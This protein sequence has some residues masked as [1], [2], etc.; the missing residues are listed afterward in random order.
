MQTGSDER[1][2][3]NVL[4][5]ISYLVGN[6]ETLLQMK[7]LSPRRPF[8]KYTCEFLSTLSKR[9]MTY[10]NIRKYPDLMTF[11]FWI[12][13]ASLNQMKSEHGQ[14]EGIYRIGRGVSF[15]IAPSNVPINFAY[16]MVAA[17]LTGNAAIVRVPSKNHEQIMV[18]VD[19]LTR[20]LECYQEL[21]P[22]VCLIR[23]ERNKEINDLLSS[24]SDV[25]II[26]GGDETIHEIR[27]SPL[28]PRATEI[29]FADRYSLAVIDADY[30]L[31]YN[32]AKK[33]AI[34]FYNDTYLN[35]QNACTSPILVAWT[36]RDREQAKEIFWGELHELV[37]EKY[38]FQ[39]IQGVNKLTSS[40]LAAA[41]LSENNRI[42]V[43]RKKDN[44]LVRVILSE[45]DENLVKYK[46]NSGYFYEYDFDDILELRDL[47]NNQ[48]CQTIGYIGNES[49]LL[50]LIMSG[51]KGIDRIVPVGHTMD[52]ELMWDG[53]DL[54]ERL[55]RIIVLRK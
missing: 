21:K 30:Y 40:Y 23:Y 47:C 32:D 20:L 35:D 28:M 54:F 1:M 5:Q 6:K 10:G 46:D 49:M 15:H 53:Y 50:P 9:I 34:D 41:N 17:I 44:L 48:R 55:T 16:S 11:A 38:T 31:E 8:D 42:T 33:T 3:E 36:G 52:F 29:T 26:W 25:R 39:D 19:A 14:R 27:Q 7:K 4:L 37:R 18:I 22:Y 2:D 51:T 12:R 45:V 24:F 43:I 13:R